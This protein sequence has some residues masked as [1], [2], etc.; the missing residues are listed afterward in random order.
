MVEWDKEES[1]EVRTHRSIH[2]LITC[3]IF[4][5]LYTHTLVHCVQMLMNYIITIMMTIVPI[6][7]N[8]SSL[9][10]LA[11][12]SGCHKSKQPRL[13]VLNLAVSVTTDQ[14][15]FNP[16]LEHIVLSS[17]T[18]LYPSTSPVGMATGPIRNQASDQ[19]RC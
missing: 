16:P 9:I 8:A 13:H 5:T 14:R 6:I 1:G 17:V 18:V 3:I 4:P 7:R 12:S 11:N 2:I 10:R 19:D 15:R